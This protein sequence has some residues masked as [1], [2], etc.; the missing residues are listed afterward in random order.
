MEHEIHVRFE[1]LNL[2][3]ANKK[4]IEL[5]QQLLQIL[6]D[7]ARIETKKE[8]PDTQDFGATLVLILGTPA[9]L[10]AFK[11]IRD[12]IGKYGDSVVIETP[13]GRVVAR[14]NAAKN[15]DVAKTV[16]ALGGDVR[17]V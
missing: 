16:T 11:G 4:A 15:I 17:E 14:G 5:R 9:I 6:K 12:F 8:N 13:D 1:G 3:S 7:N 10:A 2:A